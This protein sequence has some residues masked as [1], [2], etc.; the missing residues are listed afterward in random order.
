MRGRRLLLFIWFSGVI[1]FALS[2][3]AQA[4]SSVDSST[5][6]C[7]RSSVALGFATLP[8]CYESKQE[9]SDRI[10]F[11]VSAYCKD[12]CG[13]KSNNPIT[14]QLTINIGQQNGPCANPVAWQLSGGIA[15]S[16]TS[17]YIYGTLQAQSD[18]VFARISGSEDCNGIPTYTGDNGS[19][20]A[21]K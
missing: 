8:S 16:G 20:L 10:N 18:M 6:S 5:L 3:S 2:P 17:A 15:G 12:S 11:W 1:L 9:T 19:N 14:I 7:T 4:Q 13:V 21:C